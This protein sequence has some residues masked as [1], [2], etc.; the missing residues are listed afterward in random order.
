MVLFLVPGRGSVPGI[1][2]H[3]GLTRLPAGP[4]FR[5]RIGGPALGCLAGGVAR[6]VAGLEEAR[7]SRIAIQE[8]G[9][10]EGHDGNHGSGAKVP[11]DPQ[12]RSGPAIP[13]PAVPERGTFH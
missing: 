4:R 10:Q 6:S 2:R 13:P 9:R 1:R 11:D 7:K 8:S 3:G 12:G 5:L